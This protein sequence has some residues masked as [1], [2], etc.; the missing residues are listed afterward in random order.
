MAACHIGTSGWNYKHWTGGRFYPPKLAPRKWLAYYADRYDTVEINNSFY[1]VPKPETMAAWAAAVPKGFLFATKIWRGIT[2][3][4]KLKECSD[5]LEKFFAFAN[6]L[7]AEHRAPLLLQ[8]P[9][10]LAK[11]LERLDAFL[12]E[13]EAAIGRRRWQL[14]VEFRHASWI[15]PESYK[16]CDRRRVAVALADQQRC[17]ITD[18]NDMPFVY[19]RR[20]VGAGHDG[21]YTPAQIAEDAARIGVWLRQ[22]RTV[23]VYYNN[24]WGGHAIDNAVQLREALGIPAPSPA[25]RPAEHQ[26]LFD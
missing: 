12:D 22:G 18:P 16:L 19:I 10:N 7:G 11:N 14:A 8:L 1:R 24:D 6:Q 4:R 15:T 17:L 2:H 25:A 3:Y 13:Y 20:H 9:P 21:R 5:L 23:F 26:T